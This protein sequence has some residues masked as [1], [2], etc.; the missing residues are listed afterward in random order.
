MFNYG[1]YKR[2]KI[3]KLIFLY[4]KIIQ[5]E[6]D[7]ENK[8][9]ALGTSQGYQLCSFTLKKPKS[10]QYFLEFKKNT[11]AILWVY[12]HLKSTKDPNQ[13]LSLLAY[14]KCTLRGQS[15]LGF[16][17]DTIWTEKMCPN[18]LSCRSLYTRSTTRMKKNRTI[19]FF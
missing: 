19:T 13:G 9:F 1:Y 2:S 15:Q 12:Y 11:T 18:L 4:T 10:N 8:V 5:G 14:G 16:P 7:Y 3:G 17:K 6:G